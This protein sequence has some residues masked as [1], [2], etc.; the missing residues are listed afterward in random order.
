[1]VEHGQL[2]SRAR[3]NDA[4]DGSRFS[5]GGTKN[6]AALEARASNVQLTLWKI[7]T[8]HS[9]TRNG[10]QPRTLM[11]GFSKVFSPVT[12]AE[13]KTTAGANRGYRRTSRRDDKTDISNSRRCRASLATLRHQRITN[14]KRQSIPLLFCRLASGIG[15]NID[16]MSVQLV[17]VR[18]KMPLNTVAPTTECKRNIEM[19]PLCKMEVTQAVLPSPTKPSGLGPP[20]PAGAGEEL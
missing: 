16:Q 19:T 2:A 4:T 9:A 3:A 15:R 17:P 13:T 7:G 12:T 18:L 8:F 20:S 14:C 5:S 11:R 6:I 1:M 10:V